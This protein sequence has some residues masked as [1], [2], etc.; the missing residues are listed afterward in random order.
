MPGSENTELRNPR[1]PSA[2][3][4][5]EHVVPAP[6][7]R[8]VLLI[9]SLLA[10]SAFVLS[11]SF[12]TF[13]A[14]VFVYA[15]ALI[16]LSSAASTKQSFRFGFLA[17]FL[18]FAPQ[19]VWFWKIF[20]PTAICL[21]AVLSFFTALFVALLQMARG[22]IGGKYLWILAP[23]LWTGIEYFRSELYPL[24]FSWLSAG[25]VFSGNG[26][27]LP[28][29]LLGVYG[30][31]F[32]V[33]LIAAAFAGNKI[34]FNAA[35]LAV[36]MAAANWPVQN[37]GK[38]GRELHVAGVQ[39]EFPPDLDVPRQLD[40][41]LARYPAT[42]IFVLS[43]YAFDGP[44]PKHVREWCRR[45]ERYLIAGGKD[46]VVENERRGFRNTAFVVGPTGDIVFQ[47]GKSVPIQFFNDGLPAREQRVWDSPWGKIAIPTCYDLSYRRVTDRFAAEGAEA[48]I[49]PF[50]DVADWGE[51]Q[52][53]QHA[54]IAP[55]R[56][57]EYGVPIFRLGSSGVSQNVNAR[58]RVL[59]ECG[60]PG[61]GEV[62]GGVVKLNGKARVP[63][64]YW[65]APIC[66]G[67]VAVG[68]IG[69]F[70]SFRKQ[71]GFSVA[72]P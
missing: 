5:L 22:R 50:M 63:Q 1:L 34:L 45:N 70:V 36:L 19:L 2:A 69:F 14:L 33:F 25:Y 67:V 46:E 72:P 31:G 65:L 13:N 52:H 26:G 49:V 3:N 66:S 42:Q 7:S 18:T 54:R 37:G 28:V 17:G 58:G 55:M 71:N 56:A 64:D 11:W 16:K 47:Q 15:C 48:F 24:R 8:K 57:R 12:P 6:A 39:L 61:Q 53:L 9:A 38:T 30:I 4:S 51:H 59:A 32:L 20:G 35:V 62:F 23:V 44:V 27:I 29:G 68:L 40:R 41:V 43:E 60:F 21:W 10:P